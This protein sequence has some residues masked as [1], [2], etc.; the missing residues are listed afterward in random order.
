VRSQDR[1]LSL[2]VIQV[3]LLAGAIYVG[4]AE[5]AFPGASPFGRAAI[6]VVCVAASFL[7]G[8]VSR[9]RLHFGALLKALEAGAAATAPR[10]DRAAIDVLVAAL[11]SAN[12]DVRAKA[13]RNLVKITGQDLP[14]DPAR[15]NAWW[16][17]TRPRFARP[18][19][20]D[21]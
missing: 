18:P 21:A 15:W 16:S 13:H 20:S 12:A 14:L 7:A 11:G 19:S 6:V 8:E 1:A 2:L 9:L 17:E 5:S 3:L 4:V 10:D